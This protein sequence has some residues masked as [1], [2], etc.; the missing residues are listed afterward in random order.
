MLHPFEDAYKRNVQEQHKR[1]MAARQAGTPQQHPPGGG[2][3]QGRPPQQGPQSGFSGSMGQL[4]GSNAANMGGLM[5]QSVANTQG[6]P[7]SVNGPPQFPQASQSTPQVPFQRP[8]SSINMQQPQLPHPGQGTPQ[9][10]S[11][12]TSHEMLSGSMGPHIGDKNVLDQEVL[13]MK[14]RLE[15]EEVDNKRA[16]Q[17]TGESHPSNS[18]SCPHPCHRSPRTFFS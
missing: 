13:P 8:P 12:T 17:K 14:R 16:R 18:Q 7:T 2:L 1:A 9:A 15:S 4:Q 3:A 6:P 5:G 11:S 10:L